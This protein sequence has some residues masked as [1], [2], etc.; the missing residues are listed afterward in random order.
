MNYTKKLVT[1]M[2]TAS[3]LATTPMWGQHPVLTA[4]AETNLGLP[5]AAEQTLQ[6]LYTLQPDLK[7]MDLMINPPKNGVYELLFNSTDQ[8]ERYARLLLDAETGALHTYE[9][10]YEAKQKNKPSAAV[11]KQNADALLQALLGDDFNK[12][13][14]SQESNDW[15][16]TYTR[17]ENGLPVFTDRYVVGVN[18]KGVMYVDTLEGAPL[19][20]SSELFVQPGKVLVEAKLPEKVASFMELTYSAHEKATGKPALT[21]SLKSSGYMNAV[22]GEK[23]ESASSHTSRYSDVIAVKPGGKRFAARNADD[24][25]RVLAEQFQINMEGIGFDMDERILPEKKGVEG[26]LFKSKGGADKILVYTNNKDVTGFQIRRE[27]GAATATQHQNHP[28]N[29]QLTYEEAKEKAVQF[30]QPYLDASVK[31]LKI[32]QSKISMPTATAYSFSFFALHDGVVV[33]DQEYL[34]NVDGQTGEI[35]NFMDYFTKPTAPF[36]DKKKAISKEAAAK[37]FLKAHPTELGY[38][39]PVQ[40]KKVQAQ[41]VPVYSIDT[42]SYFKLDAVTGKAFQ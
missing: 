10:E 31:K 28:E 19:R 26:T 40:N 5:P 34:V 4:Q 41:P 6:T 3:I 36:P 33:S 13:R 1:T 25:K 32:D 42:R 16:V 37:L 9:N 30:L 39:F 11:A 7:S 23:V 24:V 38:V 14:A 20:A 22:T 18:G 35:V 2:L 21:Y 27:G 12:Y 15:Q 29:V 8:K 17:Y